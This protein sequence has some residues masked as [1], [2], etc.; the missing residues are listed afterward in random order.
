MNSSCIKSILTTVLVSILTNVS[1][2]QAYIVTSTVDMPEE[3]IFN[4]LLLHKESKGTI[5]GRC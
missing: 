4:S 2:I 3:L 1:V 5:S